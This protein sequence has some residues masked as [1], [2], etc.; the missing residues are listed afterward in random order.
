MITI[1]TRI[2]DELDNTLSILANEVDRPKGYIVRRALEM[3]IE[4]Q[5]DLLIALSR[6]EKDEKT[7]S[8]EEIEKKYDLED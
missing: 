3:Y 6:I 4:E 5:A 8:L 7:I 2:P 1:T